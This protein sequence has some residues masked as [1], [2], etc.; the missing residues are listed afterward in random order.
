MTHCDKTNPMQTW[1][2]LRTPMTQYLR[3]YWFKNEA[4]N[5]CLDVSQISTKGINASQSFYS[6]FHTLHIL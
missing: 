3:G 4:K 1:K 2:R 5:L 6:Y